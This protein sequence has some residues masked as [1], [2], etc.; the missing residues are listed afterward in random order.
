MAFLLDS[1]LLALVSDDETVK[2][3]DTSL[4]AELQTLEGH[5]NSVTSVTLS[6]DSKLLALVSDDKTIKL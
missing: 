2:L 4:G 6:L 1:K 3:W 5:S